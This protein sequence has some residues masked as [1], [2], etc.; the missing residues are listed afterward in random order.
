MDLT[1]RYLGFD[2]RN[3]LVAGAGPLS[4]DID[5]I[6]RLED[7]GAGAV[8]LPSIFEEQIESEAQLIDQLS[9]I[10]SDSYGEALTYFPAH[11]AYSMDPQRYLNLIHS[12][13]NAVDIP[14]VASLN[15][16]LRPWLDRLCTAD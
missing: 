4:G 5:S 3:P 9:T 15:G 1:T 13:V 11:T 14:I 16:R 2:L 6:M 8:V 10:G 7:V 12:A